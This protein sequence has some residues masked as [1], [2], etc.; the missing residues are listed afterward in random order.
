MS[1]SEILCRILDILTR[2][3]PR[4]PATTGLA[5]STAAG[6]G[7]AFFGAAT[8]AGVGAAAFFGSSTFLVS[9]VALTASF[10]STGVATSF[11]ATGSDF[12]GSDDELPENSKLVSIT[13]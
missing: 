2:V 8:G 10:F 13:L 12:A 7:A 9:S 6:F 5:T 3:S 11:S 1:L 4:D